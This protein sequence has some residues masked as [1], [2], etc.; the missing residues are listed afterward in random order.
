[1]RQRLLSAI[2]IATTILFPAAIPASAQGIDA[3]RGKEI[4]LVVGNGAAGGFDV[5]ARLFSRYYGRFL[6]GNPTVVVKNVPG[7]GGLIAANHIFNVAPKDGT[8]IGLFPTSVALEPLFHNPQAKY[9]TDKFTWIGNM[10]SD[11]ANSCGAWKQSGIKN[12]EDVKTRETTIGAAG[13]S[14]ESAIYSKVIAALLGLKTKVILGY[15]SSQTVLA[16]M[17]R[18][19]IDG[20][21]GLN[22]ANTYTQ[23]EQQIKAGD[24]VVWMTFG[25]QRPPEFPDAPT[26]YELIKNDKDMQVANLVFGQNR[27]N[28][29][30]SAPPGMAPDLTKTMRTAFMAT[31]TDKDFLADA[32]QANVLIHPMTGEETTAV[33]QSFYDE[34]KEAIERTI[35]IIG[36]T[37]D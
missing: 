12:W 5:S 19:E 36:R 23:F 21:C 24:L 15:T 34:P 32:K 18:G 29:G 16:A 11:A 33:Y 14:G 10:N 28:R 26:V 8:E 13:P 3:F 30:L 31:M 4:S 25:R 17:Q 35:K 2:I 27:I 7:A 1:M 20:S 22:V 37:A 9:E 6:P